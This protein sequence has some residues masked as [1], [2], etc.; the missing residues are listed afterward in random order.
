M[1]CYEILVWKLKDLSFVTDVAGS[2]AQTEGTNLFHWL[3]NSQLT[4]ADFSTV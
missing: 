2:L 3:W 1:V 4:S